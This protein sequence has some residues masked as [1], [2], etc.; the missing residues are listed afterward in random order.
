[1]KAT[2]EFICDL[3]EKISMPDIYQKIRKLMGN[4]QA[5]ID[6]YENLI[7]MDSMLSIRIVRIANSEFFG[8]NRQA[9]DLYE[10]ISL[11]G[12]IQ[13]HDL[14]LSSLCMRTFYNI[15]EHLLNFD[16]FW[17]HG[18]K[19]GIA[20]RRIARLCRLPANNR[21]FSLGLLVNIG[22]V[23]MFIKAPDLMLTA[24]QQS[25]DLNQPI[26]DIER[27]HFGF[28]YCQLGVELMRQWH[29]PKVY[30][31]VIGHH[32]SPEQ[33]HTDFRTATDI[34]HFAYRFCEQPNSDML[35]IPLNKTNQLFS[36]LPQNFAE[37][38]SNDINSNIDNILEML[39]P[40]NVRRYAQE[41]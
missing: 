31:Q 14:L 41:I 5:K 22:H 8:F 10:A 40:P 1:M 27:E 33:S 34:V 2:H 30:Q 12:I 25:Q 21:Y 4:P 29:L 23:A 28:D 32:L 3:A 35:N 16:D 37:I 11:I 17:R 9:K 26:A 19:C 24:L 20:S 13:L 36:Q 6:D 15:P 38:I 39:R 18:I 7:K